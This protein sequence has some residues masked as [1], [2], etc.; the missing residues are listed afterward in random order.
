MAPFKHADI[1]QNEE[2][3]G[4]D[5][6]DCEGTYTLAVMVPLLT[7]SGLRDRFILLKIHELKQNTRIGHN[8]QFFFYKKL[9]TRAL[10]WQLRNAAVLEHEDPSGQDNWTAKNLRLCGYGTLTH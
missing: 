6:S 8:T 1:L 7:N 9:A 4:L 3:F 10:R 5:R 2:S